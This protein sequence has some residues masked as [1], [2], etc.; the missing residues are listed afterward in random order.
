[1]K[2][3]LWDDGLWALLLG[4]IERGEVIP[5]VGPALSTITVDGRQMALQQY[6]AERLAQSLSLHDVPPNPMLNDI[7]SCYLRENRPDDLD[8]LYAKTGE[9]VQDRSVFVPPD[10]LRQ[11][12]QISHFKMFVTTAFDPLLEIAVNQERSNGEQK[13]DVVAYAPNAVSDIDPVRVKQS[14]ATI[15]HLL[16]RASC[17]P[18]EYVL[19]DEDFLEFVFALQE[20]PPERLFDEL[21]SRHL[22]MLGA[23]LP[24]WVAR[25]FL[26]SAKATRLSSTRKVYEILADERSSADATLVSFLSDFSTRTKV[27]TGGAPQ[28]I[29]QLWLRWK[30]RFGQDSAVPKPSVTVA[31]STK[32]SADPLFISYM[33]RDRDAALT[34]KAGLEAAGFSVWIDT[35]QLGGGAA[36]DVRIQD[37]ISRCSLFIPLLSQNTEDFKEGY[38]RIEWNHAVN[39]LARFNPGDVFIVPVVIDSDDGNTGRFRRVPQQFRTLTGQALPGGQVT[40]S[41]IHALKSYI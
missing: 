21:K 11:L 13:A 34:L 2:R 19:S 25:L 29:E 14:S 6:V 27:F 38:F 24:D 3:S 35:E 1:M 37:E 18:N 30:E 20:N 32:I 40:P 33:H 28:F 8:V 10:A 12:A 17:I 31:E 5:V 23:N 9:I 4:Y 16:G 22:L 15:F 41:F 39:R 36:F 7:V 26:R